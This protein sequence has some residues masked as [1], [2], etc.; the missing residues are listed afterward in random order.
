MDDK[1]HPL[2]PLS[3]PDYDDS[4]TKVGKWEAARVEHAVK[5]LKLGKHV[6]GE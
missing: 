2:S 1:L 3:V 6:L 4:A 5:K